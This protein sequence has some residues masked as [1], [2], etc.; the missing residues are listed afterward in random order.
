MSSMIE[1]FDSLARLLLEALLNT[2]WQGMLIAALVW[3]LLRFIKRVSATTRHAVWLVTLLTIGGLPLVGVV[4]NRNVP[5]TNQPPP[6]KR[7]P[8]PPAVHSAAPALAPG[9]KQPAGPFSPDSHVARLDSTSNQDQL[10]IS[11]DLKLALLFSEQRFDDGA[12]A[13]ALEEPTGVVATTAAPPPKVE[14]KTL[15]RR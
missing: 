13:P 11:Y 12:K 5:A 1:S 3:L 7:A 15:W 6:V 4:A 10:K 8:P 9:G 14:S 2:L